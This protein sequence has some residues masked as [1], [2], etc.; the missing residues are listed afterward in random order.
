MSLRSSCVS[1]SIIGRGRVHRLMVRL[2]ILLAPRQLSL[3]EEAVVSAALYPRRGRR[4]MAV[5]SVTRDSDPCFGCR[6]AGCSECDWTGIEWSA[7]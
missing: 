3:T 5:P 2:G 7:I 1:D 4:V 6:G